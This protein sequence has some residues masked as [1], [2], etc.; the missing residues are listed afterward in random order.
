MDADAEGIVKMRQRERAVAA[1]VGEKLERPHTARSTRNI[2]QWESYLP[3]A[4]IKTMI[5]M[6]WD[7]NT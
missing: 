5:K 6:G 2:L 4:C 1:P 3:K 7:R